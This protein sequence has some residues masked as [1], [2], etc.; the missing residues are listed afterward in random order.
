MDRNQQ[1]QDA[2][3]LGLTVEMTRE[4]FD[5]RTP[6]GTQAV[7]IA[8]LEHDES[9]IQT[10]YFG[11]RTVRTVVIGFSGHTRDLF[12]E[13]RQA[14]ATFPPTAHLGP[15]KDRWTPRVVFV[16]A[17]QGNGCAHWEGSYS[18][19]HR[20]LYG[21][22]A[23]DPP[24]FQ[25]EAEARAFVAAAGEPGDVS[26]DGQIARF[27]WKIERASVE[28]REK[29]SMG[30]GYYLAGAGGK[31]SGWQVRKTHGSCALSGGVVTVAAA[32][33]APKGNGTRGT[34]TADPSTTGA[35]G[36]T[37]ESGATMR[38]NAERQGVEICFPSTPA[39]FILDALK[40]AGWRWSRF[41][42]CWYHSDTPAARA[43]AA[44]VVGPVA[45][46]ETGAESEGTEAVEAM[47]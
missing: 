46:T 24:T 38:L 4:T 45:E 6:A 31:Y 23:F 30:H 19:W 37:S 18:P 34:R 22:G 12:A 16:N 42:A 33:L 35:E 8:E 41:G 20:E 9:D 7:I 15:G 1:T 43:Y 14:A 39:A 5:A 36:A 17:V 10:D 2:I 13:M 32:L 40:A 3:D 27:Q 11:S 47:G 21:D 26:V 44:A 25:T 28:H 29:W